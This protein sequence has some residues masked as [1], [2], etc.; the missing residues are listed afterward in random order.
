MSKLA[1]GAAH[2]DCARA[3]AGALRRGRGRRLWRAESPR[4]L[5]E[6]LKRHARKRLRQLRQLPMIGDF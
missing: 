3:S 6:T 2:R 1:T 5:N 4:V